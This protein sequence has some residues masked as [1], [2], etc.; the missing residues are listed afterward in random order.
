MEVGAVGLRQAGVG[1]V[2]EE[3]VVE[4]VAVVAGVG[5]GGGVDEAAAGECE[6]VRA[7][8]SVLGE[9]GDGAAGELAADDGG[10]LEDRASAGSRRPRRLA[11]TASSVGGSPSP[12][13]AA[14][15]A[16]CSA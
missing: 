6:Q 15:T 8:T 9:R 16:S 7:T 12:P 14:K 3:D 2:A 13:S 11:R 10:A 4:A 5:A 1:G